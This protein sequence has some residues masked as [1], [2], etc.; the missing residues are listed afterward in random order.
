[1]TLGALPAWLS[2]AASG[3]P[4]LA[5]QPCLPPPLTSTVM[6]SKVVKKITTLC[7]N[8]SLDRM[9]KFRLR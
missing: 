5:G 4:P 3:P 8:P 1:M 9:K 6:K 2:H 7:V